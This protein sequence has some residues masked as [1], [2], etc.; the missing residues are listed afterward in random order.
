M[1]PGLKLKCLHDQE[2]VETIVIAYTHMHISVKSSCLKGQ[3][4]LFEQLTVIQWSQNVGN[5]LSSPSK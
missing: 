4:L 3:K 5:N 1:Q 2:L